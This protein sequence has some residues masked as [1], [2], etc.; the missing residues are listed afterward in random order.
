MRKFFAMIMNRGRKPR[1]EILLEELAKEDV[2][3]L[4]L[5]Y[6]HAE[7]LR[8]YGV[9]IEKVYDTATQNVAIMEKAYNKG[10]YDAMKMYSEREVQ[11]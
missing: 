3:V 4:A 10:F 9:D 11:K 8:V 1:R 5:A 7:Y 2:Q 6:A